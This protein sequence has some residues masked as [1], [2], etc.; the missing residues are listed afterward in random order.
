M[1]GGGGAPLPG[2]KV[3]VPGIG[4]DGM[5]WASAGAA[6]QKRVKRAIAKGLLIGLF[7][8]LAPVSQMNTSP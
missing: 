2:S 8:R 7:T 1:V 4:S 5:P 3:P 6:A